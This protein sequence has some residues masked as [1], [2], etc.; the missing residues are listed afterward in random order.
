MAEQRNNSSS[1]GK[2]RVDLNDAR[3]SDLPSRLEPI[4][5]IRGFEAEKVRPSFALS[6]SSREHM[7]AV[8]CH[9][10]LALARP[11]PYAQENNS[12][13]AKTA[14]NTLELKKKVRVCKDLVKQEARETVC[15]SSTDAICVHMRAS[16]SARWRSEWRRSR[17]SCRRAS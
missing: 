10:S 15:E 17:A 9:D 3:E 16:T 13:V 6:L 7:T 2:W 5:F 11:F 12:A 14:S 4:G 8:T 1:S